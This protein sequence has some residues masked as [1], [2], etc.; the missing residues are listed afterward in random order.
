MVNPEEDLYDENHVRRPSY[1]LLKQKPW[2]MLHHIIEE[3]LGIELL[4]SQ[5]LVQAKSDAQHGVKS[6]FDHEGQGH[7]LKV[8][9]KTVLHQ[10]VPCKAWCEKPV[11]EHNEWLV[12]CIRKDGAYSGGRVHAFSSHERGIVAHIRLFVFD[13]DAAPRLAPNDHNLQ[14]LLIRY[15]TDRETNKSVSV[16]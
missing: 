16:Q 1:F 8:L 6:L 4:S 13:R 3:G 2:Q 9:F 10:G 11:T 14:R 5:V 15:G 12:Q 7:G